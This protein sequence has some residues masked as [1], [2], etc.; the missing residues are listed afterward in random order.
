MARKPTDAK[1]RV[2]KAA[3]KLFYEQGY[4]ATRVDHIVEESG[5]SKPTIYTYFPTKEDLCLVYLKQRREQELAALMGAI[6]QKRSP[7]QRFMAVI[8]FAQSEML[9]EQY[10]GNAF[11]NMIS[12]IADR[13]SPVAKEASLYI[14]ELKTRIKA[15]VQE[16]VLEKEYSQLNIKNTVESYYIILCGAITAS[17]GFSEDWPFKQ[18]I[19]QIEKLLQH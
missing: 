15:V 5:V 18:A 4:K 19:K 11:F 2:I 6:M 3:F 8:C 7:K 12:E 13:D 17:Q 9:G 14:D 16:L 10:R 1:E